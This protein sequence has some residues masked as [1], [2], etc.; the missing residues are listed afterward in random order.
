MGT[1]VW[2][3]ND[4]WPVASWAS[5]DYFGRWK[6]LHYYE[7]RCFAPVML[8]CEEEGILTQDANPNAE[9]YEVKKAIRLNVANETMEQVSVTVK[10]A[11]RNTKGEVLWSKEENLDVEALSSAWLAREEMDEADLY[12]NYVSYEC[13]KDGKCISSG[14][15]LFCPPKQFRFANPQLSVRAEKDELVVCAQAYARSVE[16]INEADDLL[17]EDNYFDMNG[18]EKRVKILRGRPEGLKVRSVFDIR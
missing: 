7:K 2:Q 5:I 9:P 8:S 4:C 17:L 16:V 11:L 12:E 18:G 13:I 14:T 6:A 3:L 10:W 15:A 1:V